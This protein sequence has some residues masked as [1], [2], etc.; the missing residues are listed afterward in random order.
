[1]RL[2]PDAVKLIFGG[3]GIVPAALV[4]IVLN[5]IIRENKEDTPTGH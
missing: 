4:A 3:S 1:L 5:V 2:L